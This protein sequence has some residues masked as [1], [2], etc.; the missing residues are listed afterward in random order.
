MLERAKENKVTVDVEELREKGRRSYAERGKVLGLQQRKFGMG[1][2][3]Q[4]EEDER[5]DRKSVV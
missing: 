1:D 3:A 2:D 4:G 5:G